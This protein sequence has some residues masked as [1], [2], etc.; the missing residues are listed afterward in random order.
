MQTERQL[1]ASADPQAVVADAF[2]PGDPDAA[3]YYAEHGYAVVRNLVDPRAIDALLTSYQRD[4]VPSRTRFFRQ[5]TGRYERNR[6]SAHGYV[7]QSFLDL[8]DYGDHPDFSRTAIDLFTDRALHARLSTVTGH[9][10]FNLMQTMLFDQNTETQPHQ[11]WWYLD[12]VPNGELAA[13]WIA[14]EDIDERAGRFYVLDRTTDVDLLRDDPGLSHASWLDWM[15][16]HLRQHP[17][18]I[19]APALSV[20]DALVWNSRTI[21]GSLPTIDPSLSRK[22][23]TAHFLPA[24]LDFGNLH[25]RKDWIAYRDHNGVK[26]YRNQ[27]DYALGEAVKNRVKQSLYDHHPRVLRA[28]RGV[29][30]TIGRCRRSLTNSA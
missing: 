11:D 30:A 23:L 10:A 2:A 20:G 19:R 27:P 16:L 3:T 6:V 22:S 17:E 8:H 4:I 12:S 28:M 21:H 15:R 5:S 1:S 13:V 14:L 25:V 29:Q 26:F 9:P 24:H 18:L 7:Q